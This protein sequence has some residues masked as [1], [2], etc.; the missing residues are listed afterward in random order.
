MNF[1]LQNNFKFS[2]FYLHTLYKFELPTFIINNCDLRFFIFFL[3]EMCTTY[4]RLCIKF[5]MRFAQP[6]FFIDISKKKTIKY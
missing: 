3:I 1:Q 5:S 6:H 4:D 2:R